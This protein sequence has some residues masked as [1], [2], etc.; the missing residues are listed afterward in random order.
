MVRKGPDTAALRTDTLRCHAGAEKPVGKEEAQATSLDVPST[1]VVL[2]CFR[3][4]AF[5]ASWTRREVGTF[6][7]GRRRFEK[8]ENIY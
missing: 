3:G 2:P 6:D 1:L 8:I 7:G 4:C 5:V